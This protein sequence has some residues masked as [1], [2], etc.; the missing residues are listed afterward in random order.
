MSAPPDFLELLSA[1]DRHALGEL[2][3]THR[4]TRGQALMTQGQVADKVVVLTAGRVKVV[5]PTTGGAE[6]VLTF[7]GPGAL[8]GEQALVDGIPRAATIV[9]VEPAEGLVI[10]ASSFRAFLERRPHAAFAL[11]HVVSA[12]LRDSD[13]RVVQ[14]AA[15]DTLGRVAARLVEL[16]ADHGEPAGDGAIAITLPL[17][18]E[19]LAGWTG[20]SLESTSKALRT[21]RDLGWV[22]TARRSIVVHDVDALRARAG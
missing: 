15:T 21:L 11:L 13:R 8:V 19:D 4:W 18:Q 2:A 16:C 7:R 12:R 5:A 17:T 20:A 22:S 1:D 3:T 14:F 10:A 6:A 9:A